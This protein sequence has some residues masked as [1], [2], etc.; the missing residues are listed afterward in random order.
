MAG[1]ARRND[2]R[3]RNILS[4]LCHNPVQTVPHLASSFAVSESRLSHLVKTGTG[5]SVHKHAVIFRLQ[6]A[7]QLIAGTHMSIKEISFA[8][9]YRHQSSFS[10]AFKDHFATTPNHYRQT[11]DELHPDLRG[12][13]SIAG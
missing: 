12:P 3:V 10:R 7:S 8:V 1:A 2:I 9:G 11:Q 4:V 13:K 5:K 6:N